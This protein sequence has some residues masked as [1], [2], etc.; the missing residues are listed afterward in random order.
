MP[1]PSPRFT[2]NANGTVT[3]NLTGLIWLKNANCFGTQ[4][5][6]TAVASANNLAKGACGLTDGSSA[7]QW[8]LPNVL[9]LRS[10]V[11]EQQGIPATWLNTQVF[12][13]VKKYFYWSSSTGASNADYAWLV[14]VGSG[15]VG[16]LNKT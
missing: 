5:W 8:R 12:S 10:L 13:N 1:W 15:G 7:G 4:A 16:R 6:S 3:D 9:E 2:D 11:N 14:G